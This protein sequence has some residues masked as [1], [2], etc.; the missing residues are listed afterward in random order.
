[1]CWPR[2]CHL[3]ALLGPS[4]APG[5]TIKTENLHDGRD[6]ARRQCGGGST[7]SPLDVVRGP[8]SSNVRGPVEWRK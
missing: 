6:I 7:A 1:E 2:E 8:I 5:K 4:G 3:R